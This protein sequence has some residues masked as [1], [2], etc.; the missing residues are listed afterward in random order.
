MNAIDL[1]L[2]YQ[3]KLQIACGLNLNSKLTP[4]PE[5]SGPSPEPQETRRAFLRHAGFFDA[6]VY[7]CGDLAPGTW[8]EGPSIAQERA[9][10]MVLYQG[11]NQKMDGYLNIEIDVWQA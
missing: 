2:I 8:L 7:P 5:T 6:P 11:Q 3:S 10:T 9:L 1:E 4:R